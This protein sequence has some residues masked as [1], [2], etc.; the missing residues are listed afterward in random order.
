MAVKPST[1][2]G[3]S[4][5]GLDLAIAISGSC[6][7]H[8]NSARIKYTHVGCVRFSGFLILWAAMPRE[9]PKTKIIG[10]T[11]RYYRKKAELSK[12]KLA[13]KAALHPNYVGKIERGEQWVSLHALLRIAAALGIRGRDLLGDL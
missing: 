4:V 8:F 13:E 3:T 6:S 9:R 5:I 2:F 11:I 10:E 1:R 7:L 12:E